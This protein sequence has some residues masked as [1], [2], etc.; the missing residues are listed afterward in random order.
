MRL[1]S[2]I[3]AVDLNI[4]VLTKRQ[5]MNKDLIDDLFG[6]FREIPLELAQRGHQVN[7]LCLSYHHKKEGLYRDR[8]VCWHSINATPLKLPGLFSFIKTAQ[9]YAQ[10]SDII[11]ACSDSIYGI[12]G[13]MISK[14]NNIPLVF[15][16]YDNFEYFLLARL[17]AIKQLYHYVVKNCDALTCV[18]R[19]LKGRIT[20]YGRKK[21]TVVLENAVRKDLFKPMQKQACRRALGFSKDAVLIGTAGALTKNRGIAVLLEAFKILHKKNDNIYLVLAGPRDIQIPPE[22][23]IQDL[24]ILPLEKV[25]QFLNALDVAVVCNQKN[26]FG[27]YC[28]PQKTREIMACDIPIVA[29]KLGSMQELLADTPQWLYEPENAKSLATALEYRLRNRQTDYPTPPSWSDLADILESLMK[30][31]ADEKR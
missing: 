17:P 27:R 2:K 14:K 28:F 1:S 12:I 30:K 7:G 24:G 6:R 11:W 3:G 29:A 26:N 15:D 20:S 19:P 13:H 5:Y 16:L 21:H 4:L 9:R 22:A 31:I 8:S 10:Q 18:S 23:N 25:P